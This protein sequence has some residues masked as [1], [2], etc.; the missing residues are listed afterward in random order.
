TSTPDLA[1]RRRWRS[2]LRGRTNRYLRRLV[3]RD[4]LRG[5]CRGRSDH[6]GNRAV[7]WRKK[8]WRSS[9]G[10]RILRRSATV[11][12]QGYVIR[13]GVGALCSRRAPERSLV[14]DEQVPLLPLFFETTGGKSIGNEYVDPMRW[15]LEDLPN[16]RRGSERLAGVESNY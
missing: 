16:R 1:T 4:C 7:A 8:G 14:G 2:E 3:D 9:A 13:S 12:R 11:P 5:H 6:R 10:F 15:H